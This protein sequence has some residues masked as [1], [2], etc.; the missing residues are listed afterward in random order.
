VITLKNCGTFIQPG[1]GARERSITRAHYNPG[2]DL[3]YIR[4]MLASQGGDKPSREVSEA[5]EEAMMNQ[6][7]NDRLRR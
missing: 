5:E 6:I 2:V 7:I 1:G 3:K 4:E